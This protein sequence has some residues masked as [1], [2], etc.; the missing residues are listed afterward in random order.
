MTKKKKIT[1]LQAISVKN[2][3]EAVQKVNSLT[4]L[5]MN[6][7]SLQLMKNQ[8][9]LCKSITEFSLDDLTLEQ[10]EHVWYLLFVCYYACDGEK[11]PTLTVEKDI[12]EAFRVVEKLAH[13]SMDEK[14]KKV[15]E[16]AFLSFPEAP[17]FAYVVGYLERQ[18]ITSKTESKSARQ[19]LLIC[20]ALV[21]L[22]HLARKKRLRLRVGE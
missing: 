5:E 6:Q 2:I 14:E 7:L 8:S 12:P 4:S 17:L 22:F 19:I 15:F 10:S 11:L 9:P 3:I 18:G 20:Y 1:K 13:H 21:Q 16:K